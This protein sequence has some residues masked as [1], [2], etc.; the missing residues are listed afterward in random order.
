M[1]HKAQDDLDHG[2]A[3]D[4]GD[5]QDDG[6]DQREDHRWQLVSPAHRPVTCLAIAAMTA[7]PWPCW[8]YVLLSSLSM[9]PPQ[10]A[11]VH[12]SRSSASGWRTGG[13]PGTGSGC[14]P[15][16]AGSMALTLFHCAGSAG[17]FIV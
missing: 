12:S 3:E 17:V 15:R 8:M 7:Q 5:G 11:H 10:P 14:L 1:H 4:A 13:M 2:P 9:W 16:S 6:R